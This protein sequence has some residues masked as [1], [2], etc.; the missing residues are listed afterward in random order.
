MANLTPSKQTSAATAAFRALSTS[1]TNWTFYLYIY[2]IYFRVYHTTNYEKTKADSICP[3][4]LAST[5]HTTQ[6]VIIHHSD[7]E[8]I[9]GLSLSLKSIDDILGGDSLT[10]SVVSVD[11]RITDDDV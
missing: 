11:E 8:T 1:C 3:D 10:L 5:I 4:K 6:I 2:I 9:H 7:S